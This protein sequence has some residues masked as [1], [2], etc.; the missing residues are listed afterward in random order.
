LAAGLHTLKT[1]AVERVYILESTSILQRASAREE[2][3]PPVTHL[4]G[5][6]P[7][8]VRLEFGEAWKRL[9]VGEWAGFHPYAGNLPEIT[10]T[11]NSLLTEYS[12][13]IDRVER[14]KEKWVLLVKKRT[15]RTVWKKL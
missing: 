15:A 9:R 10:K 8:R 12:G 6:D 13:E 1:S 3:A 5:L 14:I 7:D 11:L 2:S 4:T